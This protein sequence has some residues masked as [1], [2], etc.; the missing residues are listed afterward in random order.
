[1]TQ[2]FDLSVS[3]ERVLSKAGGSSAMKRQLSVALS[4]DD[5][6][7]QIVGLCRYR[8]HYLATTLSPSVTP[9]WYQLRMSGQGTADETAGFLLLL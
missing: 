1:M 8:Q 7:R 6:V 4:E 9:S 2:Q 3:N 5:M